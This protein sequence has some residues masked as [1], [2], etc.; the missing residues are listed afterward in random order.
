[1]STWTQAIDAYC[2]RVDPS[3]WAEPL[4]AVSNGAFLLAAAWSWSVAQREGRTDDWAV[5]ALCL[6]LTAIGIGSFLF[7]TFANRWSVMADVIPIMLFILLYLYLTVI[8]YL[9][10]PVWAG[11]VAAAAFV[12]VSG[13][14]EAW[15]T[16]A[17]GRLNGSIGYVPTLLVMAGFAVL[18]GLRD[19]P[20]WRGVAAAAVVLV[21]SRTMRTLDDQ[22]GAVCAA[23]PSGTHW[24]WHVLNGTLLGLLIVTFIR[25]GERP[26]TEAE[27]GAETGA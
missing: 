4:N 3:F 7:H 13:A 24:G 25:H 1:M 17:V 5:R 12:P 14:L 18:L 6:M 9:E 16:P 8:R 27:I 22:T 23:M 2:E 15:L 19:H 26:E 11:A 21:A 10:L 20:A